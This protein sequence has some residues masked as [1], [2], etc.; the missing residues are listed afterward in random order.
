ML[1]F[2]K[3]FGKQEDQKPSPVVEVMGLTIGRTVEIDP[4]AFKFWPNDCLVDVERDSWLVVAQ[5]IVDLGEGSFLHRFYP[6]DDNSMVQ[7]QGGDGIEQEYISEIM[8]WTYFGNTYPRDDDAWKDFANQL[9]QPSFELGPDKTVYTRVWFDDEQGE[10][11]PVS[12]W[13]TVYDNRSGTKSRKIFQTC[14]LFGR[15]LSDGSDEMLLVN[16]EEPD[17]G[18]RSVCFM[19]GK[20]LNS[21]NFN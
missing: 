18:D 16:M 1:N 19:L 15:Q 2:L 21:Q 17:D 9:K 6:A 7:I 3:K 5:G 11:D 12:L 10:T 14:M 8:I 4:L 20:A 13:E